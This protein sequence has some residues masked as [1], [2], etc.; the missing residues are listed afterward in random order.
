M[1]DSRNPRYG[2]VDRQYATRLATTA[3]EFDGPIWMVNLMKYRGSPNTPT[4]VTRRSLVGKP[5]TSMR[6]STR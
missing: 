3:P 5:T 6:Q 1:S 2:T 4:A